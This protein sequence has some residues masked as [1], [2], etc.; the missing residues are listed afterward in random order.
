MARR[1]NP[2]LKDADIKKIADALKI[3]AARTKTG[4]MIAD[5]KARPLGG[6]NEPPRDQDRGPRGRGGRE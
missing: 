5:A 3:I 1:A 2:G 4:P 6:N